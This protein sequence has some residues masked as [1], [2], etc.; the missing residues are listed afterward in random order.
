M[1]HL[2]IAGLCLVALIALSAVVTA[3]VSARPTKPYWDQCARSQAA[4]KGRWEDNLCSK[5]NANEKLNIWNKVEIEG[6]EGK[7][8]SETQELKTGFWEDAGCTKALVGGEFVKVEQFHKFTSTSGPGQLR[9]PGLKQ[10]YECQSDTDEGQFTNA[11]H[12]WVQFRFHECKLKGTVV[13]CSTPGA[14]KEEVV[15]NRLVG[16]QIYLTIKGTKPPVGVFFEP[17]KPATEFTKG[18][19]ECNGGAIKI[20][21]PITGCL[22]GEVKPVNEMTKTPELRFTEEKTKERQNPNEIEYEG[23]VKTCELLFAAKPMVLIGSDEIKTEDAVQII[24]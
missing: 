2:K 17:E 12:I 10:T 22:A 23:K 16:W 15:T 6:V 21:G 1:K 9:I 4:E 13:P 3:T 24:A 11:K 14:A 20:K 7:R 5:V 19:F 18:E 8:C